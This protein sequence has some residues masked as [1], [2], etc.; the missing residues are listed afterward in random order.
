[1]HSFAIRELNVFLFLVDGSR[2]GFY[3]S[4]K[5]SERLAAFHTSPSS[6]HTS[7][8]PL[9]DFCE[10]RNFLAILKLSY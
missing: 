2:F 6:I 9:T 8:V 4:A 3:Q 1:M 7:L 5:A 10:R